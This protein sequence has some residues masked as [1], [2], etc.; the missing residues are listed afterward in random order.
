MT[1]PF[2]FCKI[3]MNV[4]FLL[5]TLWSTYKLI[6]VICIKYI[7]TKRDILDAPIISHCSLQYVEKRHWIATTQK[8]EK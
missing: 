2:F 3:L 6:L 5:I 7:H 8:F 4:L 1:S